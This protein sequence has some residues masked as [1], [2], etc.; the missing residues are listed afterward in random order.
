[1]TQENHSRFILDKFDKGKIVHE[2][3]L[4]YHPMNSVMRLESVNQIRI[5]HVDMKD[6]YYN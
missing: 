2:S 1:M 5:G 3:T 4:T 6:N